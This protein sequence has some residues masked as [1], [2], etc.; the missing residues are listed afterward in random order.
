MAETPF[1]EIVA[2]SFGS[3]WP[4]VDPTA[5]SIAR[6]AESIAIRAE[7]ISKHVAD[8]AIYSIPSIGERKVKNIVR[9]LEPQD[10]FIDWDF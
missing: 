10:F 7:S 8:N 6:R 2:N 3:F 1:L 5:R 9:S 4:F